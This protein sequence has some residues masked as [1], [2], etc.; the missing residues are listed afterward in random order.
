MPNGGDSVL[1]SGRAIVFRDLALDGIQKGLELILVGSLDLRRVVDRRQVTRH[2]WVT[3]T[4]VSVGMGAQ[5]GSLDRRCLHHRLRRKW[6]RR[7][8]HGVGRD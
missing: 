8:S 3:V 5:S 2:D 6:H 1:Y 7:V 4:K